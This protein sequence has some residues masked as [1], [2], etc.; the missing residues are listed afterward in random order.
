MGYVGT[1][2]DAK[3]KLERIFNGSWFL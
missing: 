3:H 2:T 1:V